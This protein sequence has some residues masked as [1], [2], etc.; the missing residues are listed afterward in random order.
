M[1]TLAELLLQQGI[2]PRDYA[3]GNH[4]LSCPR[5]S[6]TR[7]KQ[8]DPCLSLTIE[9]HRALWKCHHCEWTGAVHIADD[10]P[11]ARKRRS[12]IPV[13]PSRAPDYP[14]SGVLRWLAARGISEA[15]ARRNRIGSARAFIP[16]LGA[17]VDCIA[18]PYLRMGELVNIKYR[19][20]DA[21]AFAQIKDAD[22]ILF[23]LDDIADCK[24]AIIVE[25]ECDKL[26]CEEAGFRNVL[27]VPDGAP[28]KIK[29]GE[30]DPDHAKFSY[31]S[32]CAAYLDPSTA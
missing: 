28:Q 18:F 2:R 14:T 3:E 31:V 11:Q 29:A 23:G 13:K 24:T 10:R 32:N 1:P 12:A 27:S 5:C 30:I 15:V 20:L 8:R 9:R 6:Q 25:G 4:K 19:A 17:E 21:K 7:R 26:A 16:G 22:K